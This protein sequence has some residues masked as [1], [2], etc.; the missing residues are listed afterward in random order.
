MIPYES[1]DTALKLTREELTELSGLSAAR[2]WF[3]IAKMYAQIAA[4]FAAAILWPHPLVWAGCFILMARHQKSLATL[5]HDGAHRRLFQSRKLNDWISQICL[6]SGVHLFADGYRRTHLRHHRK[7]LA[8][9]DPDIGITGGYPITRASFYRKLMRD[10]CGI[11]YVKFVRHFIAPTKRTKGQAKLEEGGE[12]SVPTW[13][14]IASMLA[15]NGTI[16]GA[17]AAAGH[18]LYYPLLW[19]L[20]QMTALQVILRIRGI[21][22]HAG[23]QPTEDQAK[24]TRTV[25]SMF[26]AW[27]FAPNNINFHLEHHLYPGIPWFNLRKVHGLLSERGA[28][29]PEN[30]VD[31]YADVLRAVIR[32]EPRTA[33][34]ELE[35]NG[36]TP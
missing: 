34:A 2:T 8:V 7:P 10:M 4:T 31:S 11:T 5:S 6:A 21:A 35:A 32:D 33:A 25:R 24:C 3:C 19:L 23:M 22:E 18:P 12:K 13:V 15:W 27:F 9:D 17:M 30:V 29:P 16:C 36:E 26:E 20:P 1:S 28:L 14:S